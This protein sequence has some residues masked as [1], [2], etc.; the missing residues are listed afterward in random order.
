MALVFD[1]GYTPG[2]DDDDTT[3]DGGECIGGLP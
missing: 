1:F 3:L 2:D